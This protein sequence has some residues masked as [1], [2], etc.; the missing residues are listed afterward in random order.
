MKQASKLPQIPLVMTL[1]PLSKSCKL[2]FMVASKGKN[3]KD[4]HH[5]IWF[6]K[7]LPQEKINSDGES[8][9]GK[10]S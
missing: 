8:Q 2:I 5:L 4:Y 9:I 6:L 10:I 3:V 1:L 7:I